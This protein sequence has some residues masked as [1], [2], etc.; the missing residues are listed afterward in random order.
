MPTKAK[1]RTPPRPAPTKPAL[2][3]MEFT[4]VG[5]DVVDLSEYAPPRVT[6]INPKDRDEDG[7]FWH[8]KKREDAGREHLT[9]HI[10]G[11]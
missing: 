5:T 1:S 3:D 2:P 10:S 6:I 9:R 11:L 8:V 7:N 4:S